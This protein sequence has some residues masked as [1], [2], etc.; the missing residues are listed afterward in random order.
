MKLSVII[1]NYNVEYF[2]EQCLNSVIAASKGIAVEVFVVDNNSVDGSCAMVKRR[3]PEVQLIENQFNAG[4]S[5]A[6]N[7]AM[8]LAKGEYILLLNPDTVVEE[9]TFR[10]VICFMDEHPDAG[11]LGVKMIDGKGKFLPESKRGLPTPSVAFYKIFG[12]SRL[13]PRSKRFGRYHLGYLDKD[14]SHE[15]EILSGAFMLMRKTALDKVGLLDEAFFMY[16]EDIDL[17]YRI[18]KGGYK[19]YYFPDTTIIHYKGESTKKSSVNYVFVFYN[20]MIIFA[21]KHFSEKNARTF[22]FL[23]HVAIYLRAFVAILNRFVKRIILPAIDFTC[24]VAGSWF[25]ASHYETYRSIDFPDEVLN[26]ALPAYTLTWLTGVW[27][28]GGY[29]YP[30]R[31]WKIVRGLFYGTAF[32]LMVYGL[33]PKD[34]QF[35]RIFILFASLWALVVYLALR[36]VLHLS[37]VPKFD[38][39]KYTRKRFIIIG[40][41]DEAD[42]VAGL[43]KQT[44]NYADFIAYVHP[45]SG[46]HESGFSGDISQLNEVVDVM[47]IDEVI[48]CARDNSAQQIIDRMSRFDY[49]KIDFKIAQPESLYLIGSN[50]IDTSGD[51]Y[52]LD[53]NSISRNVNKRNKRIF[54][55]LCSLILIATT[56]LVALLN[57]AH[58]R[59]FPSFFRVLFGR[60]SM[61]GY[62]ISNPAQYRLPR[63]RNGVLSTTSNLNTFSPN[64]ET[65]RK[66]DIIYA[67]DYRVSTDIKLVWASLL[68]M[69][70]TKL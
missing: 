58:L 15:I 14:Q 11:G 32:I 24:I 19:N 51:L 54:D 22:S 10:K 47:K 31:L 50:S 60:L 46:H 25:I 13:F 44:N 28:S 49:Q 39:R 6:N 42:R 64:E 29:D 18:T 33:L 3:F 55:I 43:L 20:A 4:F 34:L 62:S 7:Q 52:V 16:G 8:T 57:P 59:V 30:I 67:K 35:S 26:Y 21:R 1:V 68:K 53:I 45:E 9:D 48:F 69:G 5:K 41:K 27:L 63:I 12:I 56:P 65:Q 2:L 38:L 23:I 66:I 36:A 61:V 37:S 70:R 17:S 40:K